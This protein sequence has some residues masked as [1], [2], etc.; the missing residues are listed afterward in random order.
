MSGESSGID[1]KATASRLDVVT[2]GEILLRLSVAAGVNLRRLP[3]LEAHPAGAESNVACN[4]ARL[5]HSTSFLTCL[6]EQP[7]ARGI[8]DELRR[9]GV[10][11]GSIRWRE[12]GRLGTIFVQLADP[13]RAV[14]VVYD[15]AGSCAAAM[16]P[17]DLDEAAIRRSRVLHLSGILPAL[18]LS[19]AAVARR[20]IECARAAGVVVSFDVNYRSRLWPATAAAT[21]LRPLLEQADVLFCTRRDARTLWGI[22]GEGLAVLEQL[23][24]LTPAR[25]V[26][27]SD[28]AAGVSASIEGVGFCLEPAVP[29]RILDR[30]GAGDALASG[31]L[32]GLL[33]NELPRALRFGVM[34]AALALSEHGDCPTV[35]AAE[36]ERLAA[37]STTDPRR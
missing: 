12:S 9:C 5:G 10:E 29:V 14:E 4:L 26:V 1:P 19:C 20:A 6:P 11:T 15:R 8:A 2:V 36:L 17:N 13:P 37:A 23:R 33:R 22:Q 24:R 16:T 18:S 35:D 27:S 28:G 25:H 21:A 31:F 3:S 7:L 34:M 32:H 30:L